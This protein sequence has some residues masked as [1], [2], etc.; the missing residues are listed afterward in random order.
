[1]KFFVFQLLGISHGSCTQLPF[2]SKE[3]YDHERIAKANKWSYLDCKNLPSV[4]E[5]RP[6]CYEGTV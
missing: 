2:D 6:G 4:A 5:L 1:M 3:S